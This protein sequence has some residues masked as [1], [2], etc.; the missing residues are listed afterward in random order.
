MT[1]TN[2]TAAED[3]GAEGLPKQDSETL[4]E[5]REYVEALIEWSQRPVEEQNLPD[6]AQPV[7]DS[8][9]GQGTVVEEMV[10]CGDKTCVCMT[11]E[12]RLSRRPRSGC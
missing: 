12:T 3:A 1:E 10:A 9:D 8:S 5:A 4:S 2:H 11:D 7:E 6:D